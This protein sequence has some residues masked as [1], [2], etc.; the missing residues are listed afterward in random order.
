MTRRPQS[1]LVVV[2]WNFLETAAARYFRRARLEAPSNWHFLIPESASHEVLEKMGDDQIT[3]SQFLRKLFIFAREH[4]A[5]FWLAKSVGAICAESP[6]RRRSVRHLAAIAESQAIK[7]GLLRSDHDFAAF[8]QR[9]RLWEGHAAY[10]SALGEFMAQTSAFRRLVRSQNL[11]FKSQDFTNAEIMRMI[12]APVV[13]KPWLPTQYIQQ[14]ALTDAQ[15]SCFPDIIPLGRWA[16]IVQWY[17]CQRCMID[18]NTKKDL[19]FSN[20]Y[21]DADAVFLASYTGYLLTNDKDQREAAIAVRPDLIIWG[22][23]MTKRSLYRVR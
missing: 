4:V 2:D 10:L 18:E 20:C 17:K 23:N 12:R 16:R 9:G 11:Q 15:I 21:A 8:V 14:H 19:A 7:P 5:H 1:P 13:V 3:A 22:W 6:L